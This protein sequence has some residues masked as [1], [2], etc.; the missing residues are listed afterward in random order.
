MNPISLRT[1]RALFALA[2]AAVAVATWALPMPG[3]DPRHKAVL[4]ALVLAVAIVASPLSDL[5]AVEPSRRG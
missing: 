5:L 4:G 2:L 1:L 3:A